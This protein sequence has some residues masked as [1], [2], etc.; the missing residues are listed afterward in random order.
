MSDDFEPLEIMRKM[1]NCPDNVQS[2]NYEDISH[3]YFALR[4]ATRDVR[5]LKKELAMIR[6]SRLSDYDRYLELYEKHKKLA[7]QYA[8]ECETLCSKDWQDQDYCGWRAKEAL[9]RD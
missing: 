6:L 8:C 7:R 9:G 1:Y 4:Y 3:V 5:E 2:I